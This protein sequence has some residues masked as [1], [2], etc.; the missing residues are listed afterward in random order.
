M[1]PTSK[2]TGH[3]IIENHWEN[4][5]FDVLGRKKTVPRGGKH[6]ILHELSASVENHWGINHFARLAERKRSRRQTTSKIVRCFIIGKRTCGRLGSGTPLISFAT[7]F[8]NARLNTRSEPWKTTSGFSTGRYGV[9]RA[10]SRKKRAY[11]YLYNR[12]PTWSETM[13]YIL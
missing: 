9:L 4:K 5:H 8:E 10:L 13:L 3:W 12:P 2:Q 6:C 11:F 7:R 1:P